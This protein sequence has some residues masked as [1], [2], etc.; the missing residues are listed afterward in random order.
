MRR[1]AYVVRRAQLTEAFARAQNV[2]TL[3]HCRSHTAEELPTACATTRIQGFS[4]ENCL[5]FACAGPRVWCIHRRRST[6]PAYSRAI[7]AKRKQNETRFSSVV[8][9]GASDD[10]I[11]LAG[12]R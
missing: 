8:Q 9:R 1:S 10:F 7:R 4:V 3:R 5:F 2:C 12:A 6:L 11:P